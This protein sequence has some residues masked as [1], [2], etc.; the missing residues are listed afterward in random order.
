MDDLLPDPGAMA[1]DG[2]LPQ[3]GG[4]SESDIPNLT[5]TFST[6][7]LPGTMDDTSSDSSSDSSDSSLTGLPATTSS[8]PGISNNALDTS[9]LGFGE[10][11]ANSLLGAFVT[12]PA[13]AATAEGV[14]N[15]TAA[16]ALTS[17]GQ[18]FSY[19]LIGVVLFL[20]WGAVEK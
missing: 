11:A 17:S 8:D 14:A 13:N 4:D 5:P 6:L 15:N 19:L 18:L 20:I 9:L 12:N 1:S 2:Q 16:N 3:D 7:Q 10:S